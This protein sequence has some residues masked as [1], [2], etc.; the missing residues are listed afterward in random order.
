MRVV[1]GFFTVALIVITVTYIERNGSLAAQTS[2]LQEL[3]MPG[4]LSNDHSGLK[5]DCSACHTS[6]KGP[7]PAKCMG[8]HAQNENF[9]VWPELKF[10]LAYPDCRNCHE[11]HVGDGVIATKMSHNFIAKMS[12]GEILTDVSLTDNLKTISDL[13]ET[14]RADKSLRCASCHLRRDPHNEMFGQECGSCHEID[15]WVIE[16]FRHPSSASTVCAQCHSAPPCHFTDHFKQV[17]GPAAGQPNA[18]VRDCHSCH[19]TP[20]WNLIKGAGWYKT[21]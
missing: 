10:H 4:Q 9:E 19:Q 17:C 21:H 2:H 15:N 18:D 13:V 12:L 5:D 6:K 16:S 7:S 8:C 11:E 20:E 14:D 1:L 3:T